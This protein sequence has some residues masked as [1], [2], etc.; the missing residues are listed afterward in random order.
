MQTRKGQIKLGIAA[1]AV[2]LAATLPVARM[3]P[4]QS[5][6]ASARSHAKPSGQAKSQKK[7]LP[8]QRGIYW[9]GWIGSQLT[10]GQPPW[11]MSAVTH[12][13]GMVGKGLSLLEF[14]APFAD[15]GKPPC[16][17]Y[18][19]PSLRD[20]DDPQLRRDPL[21]QLGLTVDPGAR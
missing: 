17:F 10:G 3:A 15:C 8:K 2:A 14:A 21:L 20:A 13:S 9:G 11:D 19:F 16:D 5:P 1:L 6:H 12:F 18:K 7:V 4:A